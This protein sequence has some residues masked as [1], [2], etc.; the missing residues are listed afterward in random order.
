MGALF[1]T[2]RN[3]LGLLAGVTAGLYLAGGAIGYTNS[4]LGKVGG[5]TVGKYAG[6]VSAV[7]VAGVSFWGASRIRRPEILIGFGAVALGLAVQQ[8]VGAFTTPK[9][10][11]E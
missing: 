7:A 5:P 10:T 3:N 11:D 9:A 8:A 6:L 4:L 2:V 1:G